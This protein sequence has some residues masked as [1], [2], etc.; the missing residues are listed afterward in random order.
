MKNW[1]LILTNNLYYNKLIE[2]L[3]F[4]VLQEMLTYQQL[5]TKNYQD[6]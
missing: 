4:L 2:F 3:M 6:Q 5:C 1:K